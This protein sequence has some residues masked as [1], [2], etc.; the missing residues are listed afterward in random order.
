MRY[1]T[2]NRLVY[3]RVVHRK[4]NGTWYWV[5][6]YGGLPPN[7]GSKPPGRG[8]IRQHN[9]KLC[10]QGYKEYLNA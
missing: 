2:K 3:D 7:K 8:S 9:R 5:Y 10:E 6:K 1:Y 4:I